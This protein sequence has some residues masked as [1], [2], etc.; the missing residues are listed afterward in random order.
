M[1][2][3]EK[4]LFTGLFLIP[5]ALW[6]WSNDPYLMPKLALLAPIGLFLLSTSI[7]QTNTLNAKEVKI[8]LGFS[9]LFLTFLTS[10]L[11]LSSGNL[12]EKFYG[13][14]TRNN[15]FLTYL[16]LF[17]FFLIGYINANQI[18][19]VK[20]SKYAKFMII[21]TLAIGFAQ[22]LEINLTS[23]NPNNTLIGTFGNVNFQSAFLGMMS[24]FFIYEVYNEKNTFLMKLK[25][26]VI[27]SLVIMQIIYTQSV[28]GLI[29]FV[30]NILVLTFYSLKIKNKVF[31]L[32]IYSILF[33]IS[34]FISVAGI[35]NRGPLARYLFDLSNIDRGFCWETGMKI[36][37][38]NPLIGV[39]FDQYRHFY[40]QYRSEK[41][42]EFQEKNF[43]HICD[44]A[45]N[46]FIDFAANNGFIVATIYICL[47]AL[48]LKKVS[49]ILRN[50]KE[51]DYRIFSM[52]GLWIGYQVQ[53]IISINHIGIAIW[54]WVTTGILL[55]IK[56]KA[57]GQNSEVNNKISNVP[58]LK[59]SVLSYG[60]G[61]IL[62]IPLVMKYSNFYFAQ[63]ESTNVKLVQVS[64]QS[65][66][67]MPFLYASA[68]NSLEIGDYETALK[69]S[70]VAAAEFPNST[71]AWQ[72]FLINP[73]ASKSEV[74]KAELNLKRLVK[75]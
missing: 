52:I 75:K 16:S 44:T 57:G 48:A 17:G 74:H 56:P 31:Y 12:T 13:H 49:M 18:N 47:I 41:A 3:A 14:F 58:K 29:L 45:H 65:P 67:M 54:G 59:L 33:L 11:L 10:S 30:L 70:L 43:D 50:A 55:G 40:Q 63:Y 25:N 72:L 71:D 68:K 36:A 73:L 53:S 15:G 60:I 42:I 26:L 61:V 64:L 5:L 37:Q 51:F 9:I 62:V 32:K 69:L 4:T 24:I 27:C 21:F 19:L 46:I 7:L 22:K 6:P 38:Q 1:R 20:L 66:L 39:G 28:Q 35:F 2:L 23:I 34:G 8:T